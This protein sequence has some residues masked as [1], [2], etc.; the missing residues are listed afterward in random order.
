MQQDLEVFF[1]KTKF[2]IKYQ[3]ENQNVLSREHIEIVGPST[4]EKKK[5]GVGSPLT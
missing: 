4:R 3:N 5:T 1:P 2:E